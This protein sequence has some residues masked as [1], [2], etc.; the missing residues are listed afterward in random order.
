MIS[1][2]GEENDRRWQHHTNTPRNFGDR[3]V[4]LALES[5]RPI[6]QIAP[7]LGIHREALRTWVRQ[8]Q[9]RPATALSSSPAL[10]VR[11]PSD[12]ARRT[13]SSSEPTRSSKR[14][15]RFSPPSSARAGRSSHGGRPPA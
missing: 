5:D 9:A 1:A 15:P 8:A 7:D 13:P 11:S 10:M 6:A 14:P 2:G 12:S 3:A 4:R